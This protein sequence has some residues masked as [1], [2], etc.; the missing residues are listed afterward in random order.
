MWE[1]ELHKR[2][3]ED[4]EKEKVGREFP[5]QGGQSGCKADESGKSPE[6]ILF[7]LQVAQGGNGENP[8]RKLGKLVSI[9]DPIDRSDL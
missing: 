2:K 4:A 9:Q 7:Q 5:R 1:S 3:S 6:G 8:S